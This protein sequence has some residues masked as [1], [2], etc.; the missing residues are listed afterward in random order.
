MKKTLALIFI[1]VLLLTLTIP[2]A[3]AADDITVYVT[4]AQNGGLGLGQV[5]GEPMA[6]VAVQVPKG[7][8]V[9]DVLRALHSVECSSGAGGYASSDMY[10]TKYISTWF[11]NAITYSDN[12]LAVTAWKNHDSNT[13]LSSTVKDGDSVEVCVY[14][15]VSSTN[16]TFYFYGLAWMD[17]YAVEAG[18]NESFTLGV[19]RNGMDMTTFQPVNE[20]YTGTPVTVNG[21]NSDFHVQQDGSLTLSF[22]EAGTYYVC[23]GGSTDY[24]A[25]ILKVTVA[26][27]LSFKGFEPTPPG[28]MAASGLEDSVGGADITVYATVTD[29][30]GYFTSEKT[31]ENLIY[32]PVTVP[33]G[34]TLDDVLNAL[35]VQHSTAGE[36]GYSSAGMEMY[37][38]MMYYVTNFFGINVDG[39]AGAS[40]FVSA[41]VDHDMTSTLAT[42]VQD[43][44]IVTVNL[45]GM[46]SSSG[47][48]F[49]AYEY[50][51]LGY[52]D[53]DMAE[54][55]V[56]DEVILH[57]Y[58]EA[59]NMSTYEYRTT[60]MANMSVYVN[61]TLAEETV[62]VT[63]ELRISFDAPGTYD[64][65]AVGDKT[66]PAAATRVVVS[67]GASFDA[68]GSSVDVG[69]VLEANL[70]A[71]GHGTGPD[72]TVY[73]TVTDHGDY[74]YSDS[75]GD[76]LIGVPVTVPGGST[77][78]DV[79]Q[80]FHAQESAAG[81]MG[82]SSSKMDMWGTPMYTINNW[83]GKASD[84]STYILV[85]WRNRDKMSTLAETVQDGDLIDVNIYS[86]SYNEDFSTNYEYFGPGY[87][88]YGMVQAGVG[89]EITLKTYHSVMDAAAFSWA[90]FVSANLTVYVNGEKVAET[91]DSKGE[92][93]IK[94]DQ[95]GT[96]YVLAAPGETTYGA[97]AVKVEVSQGASFSDSAPQTVVSG[98]VAT[99]TK[100]NYKPIII[101]LIVAV[102]VIIIIVAIVKAAKKNKDGSKEE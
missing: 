40:T 96:Y 63:G 68:D 22:S 30:G 45:Y 19:W 39:A 52:F 97:A 99:P 34:A 62:D 41:Y 3:L 17:Y 94:F 1:L 32:A 26:D 67:E 60:P 78:D 11:G 42:P 23:V 64:I 13:S 85:A 71:P 59:M 33:S 28:R 29:H 36:A 70:S 75:T 56:G 35:C 37:G 6:A 51:G 8:T 7:S 27:G 69:G 88:D 57:A 91:V 18:V 5:S 72:V 49:A 16:F 100:A 101:G 58:T 89:E 83:F 66:L 10:G 20:A 98:A 12:S 44:S 43:G 84:M 90:D 31:G 46:D 9:D 61:G 102:V 21:I 14:T 79:L 24:G 82:Y 73:V 87:F 48:Y 86:M 81:A 95:P 53:Y 25:A 15:M 77:V 93:K 55:G 74:A 76:T 50:S 92:L 4:V 65:L 54:A 2:S 47:D 80:A 38:S